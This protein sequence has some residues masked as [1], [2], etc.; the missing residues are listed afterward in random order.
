V[1]RVVF[2]GVEPLVILAV[3]TGLV[4]ASVLIGVGMRAA[5]GRV[6]DDGQRVDA[7]LAVPDAELTLLQ[8]SSPVCS[9]CA[10][11]RRVAERLTGD[12][13]AI[14]HREIDVTEHPELVRRLGVLST[15]TTL[16][17]GRDGRVHSRIIGAAPVDTVRSAVEDARRTSKEIAA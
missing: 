15:P 4:L 13:A 17:V 8:L 16:V 11:M 9:A 10:A 12:D 14:G 7:S 3:L 1:P 5:T 2:H 6:R